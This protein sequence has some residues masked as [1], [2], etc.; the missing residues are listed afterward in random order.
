VTEAISAATDVTRATRM[1]ELGFKKLFHLCKERDWLARKQDELLALWN[2]CDLEQQRDL[3][4]TLLMEYR[5]INS[6]ELTDVGEQVARHI[7]QAWALQPSNTKV[8]AISDDSSADGSQV[9]LQSIKNKF[10]HDN[11]TESHFVNSLP[12]ATFEAMHEDNLV[13]V[14]DFIGT[15]LTVERK[16]NWMLA[17]LHQREMH[18]VKLYLVA[19]A[20]MD[21]ARPRIDQLNIAYYSPNW[22]KKGISERFEGQDRKNAVMWMKHLEGKLNCGKQ[23]SLGFM[24]SESL[25]A[26]EAFNVP[27]NVFPVFWYPTL[28]NNLKRLTLFRRLKK[29]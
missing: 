27:N 2:L 6:A 21:F 23:M 20:G 24:G 14:D 15:G 18:G 13:L 19:I 10:Q 4:Q 11:W 8:V 7:E 26:L 28:K 17:R 16:I 25:Y 3:I 22:L 9:F 5:H 29:K 1:D 12:V